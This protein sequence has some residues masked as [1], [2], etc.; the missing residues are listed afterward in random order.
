MIGYKSAYWKIKCPIYMIVFD[1]QAYRIHERFDIIELKSISRSNAKDIF[2]YTKKGSHY[3][4]GIVHK[5]DLFR[6]RQAAYNKLK[7]LVKQ[8]Y[9]ESIKIIKTLIEVQND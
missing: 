3:P 4:N 2:E 5:G 9:E 7:K 8:E 6:S 1:P